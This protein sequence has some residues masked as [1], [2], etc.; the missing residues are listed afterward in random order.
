[1]DDRLVKFIADL[2][3]AGVRVSLAESQDAARALAQLDTLDQETFSAA[4]QTTLIKEH[5]DDRIFDKLFP[6]YF[7]A[8]TPPFLSPERALSPDQQQMME[9][10]LH[11]LAGDSNRLLRL[12][13][14]GLSPTH[15]E[16]SRYA[17]QARNAPLGVLASPSRLTQGMLRQMG[18]AKLDEQIEQLSQQLAALGMTPA[19]LED[20]QSL[21]AANREALTE[22]A[23]QIV[24]QAAARQLPALFREALDTT[25]LMLRS[26][27]VL[28]EAEA[29][30]LR[31]EVKRLGRKLRSRA[32]L[33]Q[34]KGAG[35][36]LDAKTTLRA[37]LRTGGI[38][39]HLHFKKK[40][41]KPK[42]VLICDVSTSMRPA[43]EFMLRLMYEMQD[44]M[45]K[46]RSFAFNRHLEEVT[47]EF[48]RY[49][50]DRTIL[51]ILRR[52]PPG[53]YATDLGGGLAD[54]CEHFMDAVDRHTII[55]FLGDGRNNGRNPR[56]D[57]F[58]QIKRRARQVVWFNPEPRWQWGIG[59]SDMLRY[60]PLCTTIHQISNLAQLTEAV[61][62]LFTAH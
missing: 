25:D 60:A 40:H 16:L 11:A 32:A 6:L 39:F 43:A 1:M 56:L 14:S 30:A 50:P 7:R 2:R 22:L 62:I 35:K 18:M 19:G 46:V 20:V 47:D 38:P 58:E 9:V 3:A 13:A 51:H 28:S 21:I 24:Q 44:Q 5:T 31:Q 57:L 36:T 34:K 33:R 10:A 8:D 42:F 12:L 54:F 27:N 45:T 49:R 15:G 48:V 53:Y 59:D 41:L 4:L 26:F 52:I 17:Q 61:D 55:V 37:N 23:E 29:H